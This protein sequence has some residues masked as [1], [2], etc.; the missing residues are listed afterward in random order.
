MSIFCSFLD[1]FWRRPKTTPRFLAAT[2]QA[3]ERSFI[4]LRSNSPKAADVF[5]PNHD[6]FRLSM[7]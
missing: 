7:P 3:S 4:K 5:C 1:S 2:T 6:M